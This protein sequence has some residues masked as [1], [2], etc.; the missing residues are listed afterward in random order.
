VRNYAIAN[1]ILILLT[2]WLGD[3]F[4]FKSNFIFFL[5]KLA[6]IINPKKYLYSP[7]GARRASP[8]R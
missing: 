5:K 4:G 6:V 7:V 8:L 2:A 3:F 1:L